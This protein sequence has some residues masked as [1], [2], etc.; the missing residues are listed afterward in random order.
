MFNL[1]FVCFSHSNESGFGGELNISAW[2]NIEDINRALSPLGIIVDSDSD[3]DTSVASTPVHSTPKEAM[4]PL[5]RTVSSSMLDS[6]E[7]RKGT[8]MFSSDPLLLESPASSTPNPFKDRSDEGRWSIDSGDDDDN[9]NVAVEF[10]P[11][12]SPV[13]MESGTA[14]ASLNEWT[15]LP[16]ANEKSGR[17]SNS[18]SEAK[19]NGS[20]LWSRSPIAKAFK[21][22][23]PRTFQRPSLPKKADFGLKRKL[24]TAEHLED[25]HGGSTP[26]FQNEGSIRYE[27]E[28]PRKGQLGLVIESSTTTGPIVHAVKDYS[29]LFGLVKKGD[30]IVEVDGKITTHSTLTEITK[31][32]SVKPGRRGSNTNLR[33]LRIVVTRSTEMQSPAVSVV[34]HLRDSSYGSSI[35]SSTAMEDADTSTEDGAQSDDLLRTSHHSSDHSTEKGEL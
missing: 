16:P 33:N 13:P 27:F 9:N 30:K 18:P 14:S 4:V 15:T 23:A 31:L 6:L 32:L 1:T 17:A 20:S 21:E 7:K 34:R 12:P 2:S 10:G 11:M 24:W 5:R 8:T 35:A 28:A 22:S 3:D 19:R 26:H 25:E 29:P